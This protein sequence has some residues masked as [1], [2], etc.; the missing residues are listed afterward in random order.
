MGL[1]CCDAKVFCRNSSFLPIGTL[2]LDLQVEP[3]RALPGRKDLIDSLKIS[4]Q[5]IVR[6]TD[7]IFMHVLVA[8][9]KEVTRDA[10]YK[11]FSINSNIY[12][13]SL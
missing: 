13:K 6:N 10:I 12:A 3:R 5:D 1:D 9:A 11:L 7:L 4:D 8:F 2:E